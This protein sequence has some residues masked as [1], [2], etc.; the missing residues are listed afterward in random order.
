MKMQGLYVEMDRISGFAAPQRPPYPE[1]EP[2]F[3][4]V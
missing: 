3:G 1:S 2:L 4:I